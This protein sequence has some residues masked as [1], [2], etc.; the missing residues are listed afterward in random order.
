MKEDLIKVDDE[1][2]DS[3]IKEGYHRLIS[4]H[5]NILPEGHRAKSGIYN[6]VIVMLN[7]EKEDFKILHLKTIRSRKEY[8]SWQ[9]DDARVKL[10]HDHPVL[11]VIE[12]LNTFKSLS[13]DLNDD[14][15][16]QNKR[17]L[18]VKIN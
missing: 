12:N 18:R 10:Q 16:T 17:K 1:A 5:I 11:K 2:E 13:T 4:K 9:V 15:K 3:L 7:E 6:Y 14:F 8:S